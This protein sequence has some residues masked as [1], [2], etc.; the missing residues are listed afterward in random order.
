[1]RARAADSPRARLPPAPHSCACTLPSLS[2]IS[3]ALPG[4]REGVMTHKAKCMTLPLCFTGGVR[5]AGVRRS[6]EREA[7]YKALAID[8]SSSLQVRQPASFRRLVMLIH[9][10]TRALV[11]S[12]SGWGCTTLIRLAQASIARSFR[13]IFVNGIVEILGV[14]RH[15]PRHAVMPRPRVSSSMLCLLTR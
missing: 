13:T 2:L 11:P 9:V 15:A 1:M 5:A 4:I 10:A 12:R 8:I 14:Q 6:K 3:C 7:F